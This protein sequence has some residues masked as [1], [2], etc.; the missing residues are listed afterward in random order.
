MSETT[1]GRSEDGRFAPG[2]G[3]GPGN[4]FARRTAALRNAAQK[5][6]SEQDVAEVMAALKFKAK[7][8]DVA[9]ARLWLAYAAGR[10]GPTADPDTLDAHEIQVR[11]QAAVP[12]EDV[13]ALFV[14]PPASLMCEVV[15]AA[16]PH[17]YAGLAGKMADTL[18]PQPQ[19]PAPAPPAPEPAPEAAPA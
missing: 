15:R 17:L 16:A 18:M 2:N 9:A 1:S 11:R 19:P 8:G 14:R 7:G 4:P 13:E 12:A 5:S 6:A 10:P 3:G